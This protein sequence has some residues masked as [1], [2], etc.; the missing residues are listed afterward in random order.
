MYLSSILREKFQVITA[1][2]PWDVAQLHLLVYKIPPL[3]ANEGHRANDWGDL[4]D[5]LWKGRLRIVEKAG[6]AVLLFEDSQ[7]GELVIRQV[8]PQP[9]H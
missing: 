6:N 8:E 4:A 1:L 3:K 7:T 2:Q 5:P 9:L